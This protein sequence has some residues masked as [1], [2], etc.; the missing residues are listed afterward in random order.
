MASFYS[1]CNESG[2]VGQLTDVDLDC[3]PDLDPDFF[4]TYYSAMDA[5]RQAQGGHGRCA[6]GMP[7]HQNDIFIDI[8]KRYLSQGLEAWREVAAV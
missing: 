4:P 6:G 1:F 7:N 3:S 2:L 5:N 8:V